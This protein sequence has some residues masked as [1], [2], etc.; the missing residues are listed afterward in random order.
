MDLEEGS[1]LQRAWGADVPGSADPG[2]GRPGQVSTPGTGGPALGLTPLTGPRRACLGSLHGCHLLPESPRNSSCWLLH[3]FGDQLGKCVTTI[4]FYNVPTVQ[5]L[6]LCNKRPGLPEH[7]VNRELV[8][9]PGPLAS[10]PS[11]PPC[12]LLP[13]VV[14]RDSS[15]RRP[16]GLPCDGA[17]R[18]VWSVA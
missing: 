17:T 15:H 3:P 1:C 13:S 8:H 10:D 7:R 6:I 9:L 4:K 2:A 14:K 12:G 11:R 5:I 16:R 18:Q